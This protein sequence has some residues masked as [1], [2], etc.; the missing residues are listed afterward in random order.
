MIID[1]DAALYVY[2][3]VTAI[4][5]G[6]IRG[7][8]LMNTCPECNDVIHPLSCG[9]HVV[10]MFHEDPTDPQSPE[11]LAVVIACEGYWCIDPN[12]VGIQVRG[13]MDP[14]SEPVLADPPVLPMWAGVA[15]EDRPN[16]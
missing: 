12:S 14:N 11:R 5:A 2:K 4:G 9:D 15:S 6:N 13:W 10:T 16:R 3:V 8:A 7:T 1:A